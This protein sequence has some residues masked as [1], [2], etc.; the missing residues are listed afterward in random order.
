M[1]QDA[2][3]GQMIFGDVPDG[4][5][6]EISGTRNKADWIILSFL[7]NNFQFAENAFVVCDRSACERFSEV[8]GGAL[9]RNL[10]SHFMRLP[11]IL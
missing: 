1:I 10:I 4:T 9:V 7:L 6:E 5:A 11:R 2:R 8:K 3:R